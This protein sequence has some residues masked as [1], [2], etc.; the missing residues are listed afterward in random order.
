MRKRRIRIFPVL[1]LILFAIIVAFAVGILI[2]TFSPKPIEKNEKE[3]IIEN[4]VEE[5]IVD[6]PDD[7]VEVVAPIPE[8]ST[9]VFE[10]NAPKPEYTQ[11]ELLS[12]FP[13]TVLSK[14][15]DAG[16]TYINLLLNL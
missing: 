14:T 8:D 6:T 16:Q 11:E 2:K 1:S 12:K 4:N 5:E 9:V 7:Q 13:D 3:E 10:D 15:E